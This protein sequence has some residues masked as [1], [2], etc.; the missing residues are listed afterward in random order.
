MS[1]S[2]ESSLI[3]IS[4]TPLDVAFLCGL[5][6]LDQIETT[7]YILHNKL[8]SFCVFVLYSY[9]VYTW[10]V[11]TCYEYIV[12]FVRVNFIYSECIYIMWV[13]RYLAQIYGCILVTDAVISGPVSYSGL[14]LV[15]MSNVDHL[16]GIKNEFWNT[17]SK[18]WNYEVFWLWYSNGYNSMWCIPRRSMPNTYLPRMWQI[19]T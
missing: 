12:L 4:S 17:R 18:R 3:V 10:L 15:L 19:I 7:F 9:Y 8:W 2:S 5:D 11:Y 6:N 16:I 14:I 13:Q 1:H